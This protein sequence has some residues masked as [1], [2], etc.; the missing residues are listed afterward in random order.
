MVGCLAKTMGVELVEVD[1]TWDSILQ[2]LASDQCDILAVSLYATEKRAEQVLFTDPIANEYVTAFVPNDSPYKKYS[3]LDV[4]G[5]VIAV[6]AGTAPADTAAKYFK[7]AT[8]KPYLGD[9]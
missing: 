5:K 7:H 4:E 8:L 2:N 6:R 9:S 1:A 3:D